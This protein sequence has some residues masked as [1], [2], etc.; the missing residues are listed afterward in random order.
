MAQNMV[1]M[2][3][4]IMVSVIVLGAVVIPTT[5]SVLVTDTKDTSETE[6]SSGS[7]PEIVQA[8][9][10]EDGLVSGSETIEVNDS[11]DDTVYTLSDSDYSIDYETGEFN[12][13]TADLDGDTNDEINS[14]ND[15]Y[16]ISYSYKPDGYLGGIT[17]Q[18]LEY[19]P[20][21]LGVALFVSSLAIVR[22][23]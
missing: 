23:N 8:D 16:L 1:D 22:S 10:V 5:T 13:T 4:G 6:F 18:I 11:L 20:L 14:T 12:V 15:E 7:V 9:T 17:G 2:G 19:I 21:A 3:V